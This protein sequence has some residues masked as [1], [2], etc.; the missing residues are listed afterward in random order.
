MSLTHKKLKTLKPYSR[1]AFLGLL[2]SLPFLKSVKLGTDI[3]YLK[4][5]QNIYESYDTPFE[6]C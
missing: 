4:K 5:I 2:K 6:F 1:W 3:P